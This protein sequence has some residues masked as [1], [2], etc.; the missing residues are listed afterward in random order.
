[1][2]CRAEHGWVS[3]AFS[4]PLPTGLWVEHAAKQCSASPPLI[5]KKHRPNA[6]ALC[7]RFFRMLGKNAGDIL[8][9]IRV[10]SLARMEKFLVTH[11]YENFEKANARRKGI[12][13]LAGHIGAFD[14]MV[15][16]FALRG[17][18]PHVIGTPLKDPRLNDLLWA[19][20]IAT[21]P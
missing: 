17:F 20:A 3:V 11:G 1:M 12:I 21:A 19:T 14:L 5:R 10:D 9:A 15:T 16:N 6:V 7:K 4:V 13:F 18:N 8:R 2:Q